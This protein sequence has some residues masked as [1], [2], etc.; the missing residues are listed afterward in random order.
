MIARTL[1]TILTIS[2]IVMFFSYRQHTDVT[3][4]VAQLENNTSR[5]VVEEF[6]RHKYFV[7][8]LEIPH[9]HLTNNYNILFLS[10]NIIPFQPETKENYIPIVFVNDKIVSKGWQN[11]SN[12]NTFIR[13]MDF[14][15]EVNL[16]TISSTINSTINT[17]T[18]KLRDE[19]VR[20]IIEEKSNAIRRI[21]D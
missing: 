13:V 20:D 16:P 8:K 11:D 9:N 19:N 10:T 14:N 3:N 7:R 1:S 12:G 4:F 15:K 17:I 2:I 18:E 21:F 6:I 5:N